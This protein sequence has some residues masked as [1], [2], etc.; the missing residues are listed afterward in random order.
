M[1]VGC[2]LLLWDRTNAATRIVGDTYLGSVGTHTGVCLKLERHGSTA[3]GLIQFLDRER[4]RVEFTGK[5]TASRITGR[6]TGFDE[7]EHG[8]IDLIGTDGMETLTGSWQEWPESQTEPL[9]FQRVGQLARRTW[10]SGLRIR[11]RGQ[12]LNAE[13]TYPVLPLSLIHI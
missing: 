8:T 3:K 1:V 9:A 10:R 4:G 11:D 7:A 2:A 5:I 6:F 13:M 12:R